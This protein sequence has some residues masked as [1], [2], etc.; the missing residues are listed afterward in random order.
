MAEG[1]I[2]RPRSRP[3][4]DPDTLA[5]G[6]EATAAALGV[7][8]EEMATL[9]SYET[10][11]T[12]NPMQPGPTTKWGQHRGFIQFGEPQAKQYG[13]DFSNPTN[14]LYSQLGENGAI[15]KYALAHGF[16][17]GEMTAA[18]LYATINAGNPFAMGAK[19]EAAGGAPGTVADKYYKQMEPHRA[20]VSEMFAGRWGGGGAL[21]DYAPP[22]TKQPNTDTAAADEYDRRQAGIEQAIASLNNLGSTPQ[23]RVETITSAPV[24]EVEMMG[25]PE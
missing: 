3:G 22:G 18:Q 4:I 17:P 7:S 19:D 5:L 25:I 15:V 11:G 20:K 16:K 12:F 24:Q 23:G 2:V 21:P 14:A 13:V 6:I 9:I 10:G 8:P 1:G